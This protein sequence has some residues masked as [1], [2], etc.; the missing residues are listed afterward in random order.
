MNNVLYLEQLQTPSDDLIKEFDDQDMNTIGYPFL[1]K[2]R[3]ELSVHISSLVISNYYNK[4]KVS[5]WYILRLDRDKVELLEMK[6]Q[7]QTNVLLSFQDS[8]IYL[9]G[10]IA[11]EPLLNHF[12]HRLRYILIDLK[13]EKARLYEEVH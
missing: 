13:K 5:L 3:Q 4:D 12:K 2:I 10:N 6:D 9:N 1:N 8:H 11:G 7:S